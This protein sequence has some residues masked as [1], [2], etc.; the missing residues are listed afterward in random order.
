MKRRW[1]RPS[2]PWLI[3]PLDWLLLLVRMPLLLLFEVYLSRL[4]RIIQLFLLVFFCFT[5]ICNI[6]A[7]SVNCSTTISNPIQ[8][9]KLCWSGSSWV[10]IGND[11]KSWIYDRVKGIAEKAI[12][13]GGILAVGALVWAGIQ[14]TTAYG[15]DEKLKH[16]KT[17]G[18]YAAIG[19]ILL[20][21]W[22]GLVDIFLKFIF[23]IAG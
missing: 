5:N 8:F 13:L 16:G 6:F 2:N 23:K 12:I 14:Y 11:W 10:P 20:M 18:I 3:V 21:A 19:L 17:T 7:G 9:L 1:R 4:M 15:D 22:F